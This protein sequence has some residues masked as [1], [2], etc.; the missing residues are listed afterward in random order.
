MPSSNIPTT[1][2]GVPFNG[3]IPY[4]VLRG[5]YTGA[6]YNGANGVQ[7]TNLNDNY[8]LL[9]NPYPSSINALKFLQT[10]AYNASTNPTGQILGNV[11]LWTHGTDPLQGVTNPFYGSFQYNYDANDYLT[12]N[13][14]GSTT[15]GSADIIRS[16]QAF[17]VQMIDGAT[18]SGTVNFNNSMRYDA[19]S[20]PYT[21]SGFFKNA[22]IVNSEIPQDRHRL[23]LD[24]VDSNSQSSGILVGYASDATN[25]FD[26]LFDAP[27]S[28]PGGMKLFST[29]EN[30]TNVYEIQGRG[31]PFDIHD[32][33]PIGINAP[34][35]GNYS[36]AIAALDG[37][38][39]NQNIY[40]KDSM[41]NILHDLK[42][43]PYH[44]ATAAG[45][46][47]D[48][49]KIVYIDNALANPTHP[50]NENSILV[51]TNTEVTV[52]SSNLEMASIEVYNLLGQK[53]DQFDNINSTRAVLSG[54]QKNNTTL[55]LKIKL[56]SGQTV[57]RKI[58]Y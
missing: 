16:G 52:N 8:N 12:I 27:T 10:N 20:N 50:V 57:T 40:L 31:L 4:T 42:A 37:L 25:D 30:N 17:F 51:I 47:K 36:F 54:L 7:I 2:T 39:E 44:F 14:L 43:A 19:S 41:L 48:R 18:G 55:L 38:F 6:P 32:E 35:Q 15:P 29:I 11:K 58:L 21:N 46:S 24:L 53:L 3:I 45:V 56:Q 26:N 33:I 28:V 34:T 13:Y 22:T 1:F 5:N 49:F 9:G 23:W